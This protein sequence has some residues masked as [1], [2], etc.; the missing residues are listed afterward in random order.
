MRTLVLVASLALASLVASPVRAAESAL[1]RAVA[2]PTRS[3]KFVARDAARHPVEELSFFGV[4]PCSTVIEIWPGGGYWTQILAPLLHDHGTYD[5]AMGAPDGD[6]TERAFALS[7]AFTTMLASDPAVYGHVHTT[8]LGAHHLAPAPA[9]SADVVLTFRN[10]HN[11]M[12]AGDA[13]AILAAIHRTLKPGGILGIEEHRANTR[14]PQDPRATSG[15][16]RQ[17]YATALIEKAGFR[18]VASSEINANPRDTAD[19]PKGVWTL[20]PSY[21]LGPVDHAKYAA[22]GEAD[23][24]VLKFRKIGE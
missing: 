7:P 1:Q 20:P 17:D 10:L 5:V 6:R 15:Y 9:D 24:F 3:P 4:T 14:T 8:V 22:I 18:L 11:W 21:A 13:E 16:V 19:W 12:A 23:N 2:S